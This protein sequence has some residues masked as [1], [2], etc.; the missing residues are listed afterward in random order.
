MNPLAWALILIG[1]LLMVAGFRNHQ[2]NLLS[3]V[4]GKPVGKTTLK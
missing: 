2:E 4:I 3:A 1:V